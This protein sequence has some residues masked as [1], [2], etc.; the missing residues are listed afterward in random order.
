MR[1]F[2]AVVGGVVSQSG[3]KHLRVCVFCGEDLNNL[4]LYSQNQLYLDSSCLDQIVK[5]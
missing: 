2:C 4:H 1:L 5:F 3:H